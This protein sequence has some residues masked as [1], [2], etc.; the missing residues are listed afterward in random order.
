MPDG[1]DFAGCIDNSQGLEGASSAHGGY[2]LLPCL[3][4]LLLL[5]CGGMR[6]AAA[7]LHVTPTPSPTTVTCH[8]APRSTAE[9][10]TL[11]G[12]NTSGTEPTPVLP[13]GDNTDPATAAA[14]T[15]VLREMAACLTDGDMLR[16]YALHSDD[17]LRRSLG[18]VDG[19]AILTT[20]IPPLDDGNRAR[21]LGP[22]HVQILPDGRVLA[23]VLLVVGDEPRPDP[24]R[25]RV[26][27]F[28]HR[29]GNWLVDE[30]IAS[31]RIGGCAL[32]VEVA[33]VVGP[34]PG[35]LFDSWSASCG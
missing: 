32:P 18:I 17:W 14:I 16:F 30:T 7:A 1:T 11:A 23:A 34:P 21:Y 28:S 31:V 35:A 29:D 24:N 12:T 20:S 2:R 4:G 27:I 25:T 6:Q 3:V 9:I 33:V 8:V 10:L 19:M 15:A 13:A 5:A 22:W 26:L